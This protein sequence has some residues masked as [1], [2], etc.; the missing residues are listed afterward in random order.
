MLT[1]TPKRWCKRLHTLTHMHTHTRTRTQAT[2]TRTQI[3]TYT[4]EG[5]VDQMHLLTALVIELQHVIVHLQARRVPTVCEERVPAST[6][7]PFRLLEPY[8]R[9]VKGESLSA[10][11]DMHMVL[12]I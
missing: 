10:G 12:R 2:P 1:P 11:D 5:T 8:A 3:K 4:D 6:K 7:C 9:G